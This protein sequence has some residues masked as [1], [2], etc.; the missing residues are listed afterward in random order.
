MTRAGR[1]LW[2]D[3][4]AG[5]I[6]KKQSMLVGIHDAYRGLGIIHQRTVQF[7]E[8]NRWMIEDEMHPNAKPHSQI[9]TYQIQWLLPDW[10]WEFSG[11]SVV[12][13]RQNQRVTLTINAEQSE[14][15]EKFL[16]R[17]GH[18]IAGDGRCLPQQGWFSPTYAV[19]EPA[20][21]FC[22]GFRG[23][24]PLTITSDWLLEEI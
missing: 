3:W 11:D 21:S 9:Q 8:P 23:K 1:F 14:L 12:I 5:T 22:V 2:L 13:T 24:L 20:M 7:V 10:N 16:C 15:V 6:A 4:S 18:L 19:K 17:A